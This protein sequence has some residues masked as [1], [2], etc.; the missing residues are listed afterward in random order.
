MIEN[1]SK[2]QAVYTKTANQAPQALAAGT[3]PTANTM[4]TANKKQRKFF[5]LSL[6]QLGLVGGLLSFLVIGGSLLYISNLDRSTTPS[7][8]S[9][10]KGTSCTVAF[11]VTDPNATPMPTPTPTATPTASPTASPT[12]TPT[13]TPTTTPTASPST[14]PT[15]A[16][17]ATPTT[18]PTATPTATPTQ[19]KECNESCSTQEECELVDDDHFC[20]IDYGY[21][22]RHVN[23][24]SSD[25][26]QPP[27]ETVTPTVGCQ[28]ICV[29]S[30]DCADS[31]HICF[32]TSDGNRCR[33]EEYPYSTTCTL[34][35]AT[36]Q[37]IVEDKPVYVTERSVYV[38]ATEV[39]TEVIEQIV[40]VPSKGG[41]PELPEELPQTGGNV[42][43]LAVGAGGLTLL[44]LLLLLFL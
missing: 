13:T 7:R 5:G 25:N 38:P 42:F 31:N 10:D 20:S 1:A 27:T 21:R 30:A 19:P 44:G 8:P 37:P 3:T 40:D 28:D 29:T 35:V 41:Q 23:N 32:A 15:T 34:P 39:Q 18:N 6:G 4:N 11:T 17:T 26:C 9:A 22:C 2:P 16:P 24:P 43:Q 33:L 12:A 36:T 14:T